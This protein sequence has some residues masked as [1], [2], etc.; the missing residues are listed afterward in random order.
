MK[1]SLEIKHLSKQNKWSF[2]YFFKARADNFIHTFVNSILSQKNVIQAF[3][4]D[5]SDQFRN[6][7]DIVCNIVKEV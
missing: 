7:L 3:D 6:Y 4:I 2:E 5:K 1:F